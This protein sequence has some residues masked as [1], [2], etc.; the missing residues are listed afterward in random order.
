VVRELL[1]RR[2]F[3]TWTRLPTIPLRCS[4][5]SADRRLAAPELV[6]M[7]VALMRELLDLL[8]ELRSYRNDE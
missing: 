8:K 1:F 2:R 5:S 4:W 3:T 6:R 7:I